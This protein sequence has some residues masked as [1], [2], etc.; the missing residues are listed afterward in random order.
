MNE[1][2]P[3]PLRVL[4]VDDQEGDLLLMRALLRAIPARACELDWACTIGDALASGQRGPHDLY[5]IDYRLGPCTGLDLLHE[6]DEAGIS[7]P[8]LIL[9]AY[10]EAELERRALDAGAAACL[11]KRELTPAR[12]ERAIA[13]AL[14]RPPRGAKPRATAPSTRARVLI[15]EDE[16][17]LRELW[18]EVL[19]EAGWEVLDAASGEEA[20][21][22]LEDRRVDVALADLHLPGLSGMALVH[23]LRG[24]SASVVA[25][26]G[27]EIDADVAALADAVLAKPVGLA[28]IR[29]ALARALGR[30]RAATA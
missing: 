17:A 30:R 3:R 8:V 21:T 10:A 24:R 9:T 27:A 26:S 14:A 5:L 2:S 6:L 20:L 12:L 23:A 28:T 11:D 1:P 25:I 4:L 7:A 13:K 22:L 18:R 19:G 29:A 16:P 15:I